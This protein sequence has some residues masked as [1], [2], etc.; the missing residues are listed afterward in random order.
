MTK[1]I[2][3]MNGPLVYQNGTLMPDDG[4]GSADLTL[5]NAILQAHNTSGDADKLKL[6]FDA[7]AS[8]DITYVGII[9]T[10]RASGMTKFPMPYVL[11]CCHNSLCAVGGTI[12][13]D[14]HA[15]GLS[16]AKKYGGIFVPPHIAVIHQYMRERMAGCG[17]MLLGSDSHTRYGA[18]G[19][20]GVGEGGPELAKQ[21]VGR[22]YDID[23]PDVIAIYLTGEPA[24]G[25]GP[26]DVALAII[27]AVFK[28]GFVKNK[29]ME[30]I[31]PGIAS[32]PMDYRLGIDVMTTETTC[33][34]SIWETDEVV[35]AYLSL[36]GRESDYQKLTAR[37]GARY[38]GAVYVDLSAIRPMIALPFHPSN[39]YPID[40]FLANAG[41]L[42]RSVEQEAAANGM[43]SYRLTDK[44]TD[45]KLTVDQGVIAGCA[46]GLFDNLCAAADILR[47]HA[48]G[49][50]AFTLNCYPASQ[51]VSLE[52]MRS[53]A[54]AALI[55]AGAAYKTA[56]CGPCFGAGDVPRNNG[57]SIRHT[58]RN[59]PNREGSKP[60][61]HQ[62]AAVAL[63]DARSIEATAAAGG[64][65]TPADRLPSGTIVPVA[66]HFD[67]S[68]YQ[69]RVYDGIGRAEPDTALCFGPNITD[70]PK[71]PSLSE[72]LLL[73]FAAVIHDPV[74]TTDELIP[75]GETSSYRSNPL[76]LAEFALSRKDPDYVPR[77]KACAA[78]DAAAF[79][80][81]HGLPM[82]TLLESAVFAVK[83][84]DGSAREQAA[85]CQ[86]VLGGGANV[87]VEYATKRYRSNLI[88][89]GMLPLRLQNPADQNLF[90][91]GDYLFLR[92]IRKT[93]ASGSSDVS[94]LLI[95]A[96][97]RTE[98]LA[99]T[100]DGLTDAERSILL[101]GSL[102]NYYAQEA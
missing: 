71:M 33:L 54:A 67:G 72:H 85:S 22:T 92:D 1:A 12:N 43:R 31:G 62:A 35:R 65:L 87:A 61:E 20:L 77:A 68:V 21:L 36:V 47:D 25:V 11:T 30:F 56:F 16:A 59:F 55:A 94:A 74:T 90:D 99:M 96:D 28:N 69:N 19:T 102:I 49:T 48:T 97:G 76:R 39:V 24:P 78:E 52:L 26:Q 46:G 101:A 23:R 10:A 66:Y 5:A 44:L 15:F 29:V 86:R 73:K 13:A 63:M 17:K 75:S 6:R 91:V 27:G 57:L 84:G 79:L 18:L 89:W 7:L 100:L 70:W 98:T 38:A 58:T 2:R 82:D 40:E 51:P 45:G 83:P 32:L 8:H 88:N 42:L 34:T 41:D 50:G 60:G 93:V 53:G 95:K 37:S 64:V 14:D 9:Q 4:H 80:S 3:L 81:A